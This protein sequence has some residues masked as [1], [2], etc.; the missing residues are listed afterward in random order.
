MRKYMTI[1]MS[2][3]SIWGVPTEMIAKNRAEY[4]AREF[5]H[6]NIERSLQED[7]LPLFNKDEYEI[8]DWAVGNMDWEDF[9][10][11]Q[12]KLEDAPPPNFQ[13]EWITGEKGYRD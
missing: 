4:Y 1:T 5:A 7:T 9:D 12:V 11:F 10:G 3:G 13:E 6:N 2:D 8:E